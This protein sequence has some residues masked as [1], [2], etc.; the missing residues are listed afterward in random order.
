MKRCTSLA[1]IGFMEHEVHGS[2]AEK[3]DE[4]TH[5]APLECLLDAEFPFNSASSRLVV[6]RERI[7]SSNKYFGCVPTAGSA[8][9]ADTGGCHYTFVDNSRL[10]L[11]SNLYPAR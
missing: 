8:E 3:V 11:F 2:C 7:Q 9:S 1:L 6:L 5:T 4:L 10:T